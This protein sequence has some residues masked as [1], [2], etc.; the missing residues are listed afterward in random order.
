MAS[1]DYGALPNVDDRRPNTKETPSPIVCI[2]AGLSIRF[3]E[4]GWIIYEDFI[5]Q[6]MMGR[7]WVASTSDELAAL[8]KKYGVAKEQEVRPK[9]A[10]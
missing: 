3:V 6:G 2:P 7:Q 4:N 9:S 5:H 10:F 1:N 8:I